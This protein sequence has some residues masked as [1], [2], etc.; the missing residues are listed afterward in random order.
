MNNDKYTETL[1][2]W[3]LALMRVMRRHPK[4]WDDFRRLY[5]ESSKEMSMWQQTYVLDLENRRSAFWVL[6]EINPNEKT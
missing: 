4:A 5:P 1:E 2:D 6:H 3:V